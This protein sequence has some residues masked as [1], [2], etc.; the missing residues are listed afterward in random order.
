[1][2]YKYNQIY[3]HKPLL[4]SRIVYGEFQTCFWE[5]AIYDVRKQMVGVGIFY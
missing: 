2:N 1:M 3:I 5:D 4:K